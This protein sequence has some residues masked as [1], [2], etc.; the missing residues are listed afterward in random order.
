MIPP[1]PPMSVTA[2]KSGTT[3]HIAMD[4]FSA[5]E[6]GSRCKITVLL[7]SDLFELEL[8]LLSCDMKC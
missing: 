8:R 6:K 5:S 2:C 3:F 1:P 4:S 7:A